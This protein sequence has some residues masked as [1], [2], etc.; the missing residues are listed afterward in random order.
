LLRDS[1]AAIRTADDDA[2]KRAWSAAE[3]LGDDGLIVHA[4]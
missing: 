3:L 2:A 1:G 4:A